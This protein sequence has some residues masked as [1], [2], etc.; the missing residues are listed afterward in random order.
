MKKALRILYASLA[1]C[2]AAA[3]MVPLV[4]A[5]DGAA[6]IGIV[7][8]HGK[9]GSPNGHVAELASALE[10][11]G[12][13]VANLE[14][15]WSGKREYDVD[16]SAADKEV[17]NTLTALR[18]KGAKKLF[19]AGHSQGGLFALRFG[20]GHLVDGIIAI[21]PGG[22]VNSPSF[23]EKLGSSVDEAKR[24][25]AE[26]K[27]NEKNQLSDY[28]G[29]RGLFYVTTTPATYLTWF[30]PSGEMNQLNAVKHMKPEIPVLYICPL[31]D[32]PA[33]SK[34]KQQMFDA[35]PKNQMSK[36]YE[37]DSSH[38]DAPTASIK[39]IIEWTATVSIK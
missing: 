14:M 38:L 2:F 36:L 35:L 39:E 9:G 25:I 37:P 29:S 23:R 21:A 13:L 15:P 8:M 10:K 28:E 27:G 3:Y 16:V 5:E 24:L 30:D 19:V 12:I 6:R 33:L 20:G 34:V 4:H 7:I 22:N 1:F 18:E 26:G 17:E 11:Q 31:R 32:Y